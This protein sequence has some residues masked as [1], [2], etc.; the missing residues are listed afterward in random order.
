M[1]KKNSK[2]TSKWVLGGDGIKN[3]RIPKENKK[4]IQEL[5]KQKAK[6]K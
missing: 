6:K 1:T 5:N 2:E 4:Y 3:V